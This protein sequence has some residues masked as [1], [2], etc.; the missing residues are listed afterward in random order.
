MKT[1]RNENTNRF[2]NRQIKLSV[3]LAATGIVLLSAIGCK[4]MINRAQNLDSALAFSAVKDEPEQAETLYISK[5]CT[6]WGGKP[7]PI[8]GLSLATQL[9]GTGSAPAPSRLRENLIKELASRPSID[10]AKKLV[11]DLDT[12]IVMVRGYLPP[13]IRKGEKFDLEVQTLKN[14]DA[15]SIENGIVLKARMRPQARIGRSVKTGHVK[16]IAQ[17]EVLVSS[18]FAARDDQSTNLRGIIPG[19]GTAF[20]DRELGLSLR[21]SE[22]HPKTTSQIAHAINKRFTVMTAG[23]REGAAEPKTDQSINLIVPK[24]YKR[25]VS[26]YLQVIA[27]MAYAETAQQRVNR[28]DLL[29]RELSDP[30]TAELAA[31][32]L[33]AMG[34]DGHAALKRALQNPNAEVRFH[35]AL[36][37]SY[38]DQR[39]GVDVLA[40]A[41]RDESAF[42]WDALNGL[43]SI[44]DPAAETALLELLHVPSNETRYGAFFVLHSRSSSAPE[45]AGH[46][47]NDSFHLHSIESTA[48]AMLHFSK[49]QRPEIVVFNDDQTVDETFLYIESGLTVRATGE[50]LIDI[51]RYLPSGKDRRT[52][53]SNRVADLIETLADQGFH[54]SDILKMFRRAKQEGSLQSRLVVNALPSPDREYVSGQGDDGSPADRNAEDE[55]ESGALA[56]LLK[57]DENGE[58]AKSAATESGSKEVDSDDQTSRWAKFRLF[59]KPSKNEAQALQ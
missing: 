37:L 4:N 20:V 28:L 9:D 25:N 50:E 55:A 57:G 1:S 47:L 52:T 18:A 10:N 58:A 17:G 21:S 5:T 23:G 33:E 53:C 40:K 59:G 7:T 12:E 51:I 14:S 44:D 19:G 30:T 15:E 46:L 43:A 13:G 29:D 42:R 35:A 56:S 3:C 48:D 39:D 31:L 27:N 38:Q 32:R 22:A 16:A 34:I 6:A 11:N 26:R 54:Y 49:T 24:Q 45:L 36:A 2:A 8:E 41:A